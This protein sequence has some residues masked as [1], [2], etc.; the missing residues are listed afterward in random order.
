MIPR[1]IDAIMISFCFLSLSLWNGVWFFS[2][3]DLW[4]SPIT[5]YIRPIIVKMFPI[6]VSLTR[7]IAIPNGNQMIPI[8]KSV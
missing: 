3:S 1:R 2:H 4:I 8:M 7:L 6:E 5:K